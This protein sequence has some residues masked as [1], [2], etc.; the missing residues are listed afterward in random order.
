MSEP[1][2]RTPLDGRAVAFRRDRRREVLRIEEVPLRPR[3]GLRA[4]EGT[5]R[6]IGAALGLELP[7]A[8]LRAAAGE[9]IAAL[10]LGPD[11]WLLLADGGDADGWLAAVT[12]AA[13]GAHVAAVDLSHRFAEIR[14]AG[15]VAGEV[16]AAGCPLDLDAG[17]APPGFASRS[18][19]G[20]CEIVLWRLARDRF[21]LLAG[22]SFGEYVWLFLEHAAVEHGTATSV[23]P[24]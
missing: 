1:V 12:D 5:A 23:A 17:V 22:R 3:L 16:L 4:E 8:M 18:L 13:G 21:G 11:E 10:R 2:L 19:L 9:G 14:L 20:K 15:P 7:G 6:R 24:R